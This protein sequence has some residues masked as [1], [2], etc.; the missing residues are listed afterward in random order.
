MIL[1]GIFLFLTIDA[2]SMY[3]KASNYSYVNY[4]QA[5]DT[6]DT[7][8]SDYDAHAG[9]SYGNVHWDSELNKAMFLYT[10]KPYH[11]VLNNRMMLSFKN[12][13]GSFS[14]PIL[15]SDGRSIN[16]SRRTTASLILPNGDYIILM[17]VLNNSTGA[18]IRTDLYRSS[19][20]G[21]SWD[22]TLDVKVEGSSIKG[23]NGDVCGL[24]RLNSGRLISWLLEEG[25]LQSRVIY[26]DDEGVSWN[27]ADML[28]NP[29]EMTEP[30][31][32]ELSDGTI[33]AYLRENIDVNFKQMRPAFV[34]YSYD[35]GETWTNPE[36]SA[37]I[38]N[39]TQG[40]G[41][42][43]LDKETGLI[44]FIHYSRCLLYTSPS[45]RD[46]QKSRMPSSA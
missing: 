7:T 27:Y 25:T 18:A 42:M 45:P 37:S 35:Q 9:W 8:L 34:T 16:E 15:V 24:L 39:Y 46:R 5:F 40:N 20:K 22:I 36:A 3:A 31:W 4:G 26:S 41:T 32:V 1:F 6:S 13:D 28:G 19:N 21:L 11:S 12:A 33:V 14:D 43:I 38:L 29:S 44:E 17:S 10:L 30:A 2:N 23:N